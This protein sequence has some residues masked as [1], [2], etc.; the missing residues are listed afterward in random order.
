MAHR[1]ILMI[2]AHEGF[3]QIEY[4]IPKKTFEHAGYAV[5][6]ASNKSG[7][8]TAKD[9]SQ[10]KVDLILDQAVASDYAAIVLVGGP[11]AMDNLDNETTYQLAR[12]AYDLGRL[13]AAICISPRILAHASLLTDVAATGWDGDDQLASIYEEYGVTYVQAPVVSDQNFITATDPSA[14]QEF[15]DTIVQ[16]LKG[17]K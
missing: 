13:I 1:K 17:S 5:I 3:Q 4:G 11:G 14:S 15:A 8:A 2:I 6:T 10:T 12:E 9:K 7:M 16:S